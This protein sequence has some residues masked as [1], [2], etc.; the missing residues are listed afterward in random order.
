MESLRKENAVGNGTT[1]A[2]TAME[3]IAL[4]AIKENIPA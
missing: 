4:T 2:A 1:A 3:S